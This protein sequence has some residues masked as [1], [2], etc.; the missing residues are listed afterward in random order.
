MN[1]RVAGK[2]KSKGNFNNIPS[3]ATEEKEEKCEN[4]S[5]IIFYMQIL[6]LEKYTSWKILTKLGGGKTRQGEK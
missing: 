1:L 6:S 5:F 3:W 2:K 4:I